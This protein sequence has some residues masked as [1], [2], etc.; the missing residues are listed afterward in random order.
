MRGGWGGGVDGGVGWGWGG[1]GWGGA[2]G[3]GGGAA[4][5]RAPKLQFKLQTLTSLCCK[6]R[7]E[8]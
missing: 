2:R 6:N 8:F 5:M 7:T 4:M 3:G 1:G